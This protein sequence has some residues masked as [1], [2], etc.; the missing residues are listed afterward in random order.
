M[1]DA[2]LARVRAALRAAGLADGLIR[3]FP[4]GTATAADAA[5]A[6]GCDVAAIAKSIVFRAG[7]APVLAIA[8]GANRVGKSRLAAVLGAK[9]VPASP[10]F[11]RDATG[12]APGGVSPAGHDPAMRIVIDRDLFAFAEVWA[13]A[14][15]PRHVFPVTPDGLVRLTGGLVADIRQEG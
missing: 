13:A 4:A 1:S 7:D 15:T 12:F 14:G 9:L 3:E 8:S 2:A 5:A 10:D 6:L 11:V